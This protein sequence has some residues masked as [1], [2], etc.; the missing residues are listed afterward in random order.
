MLVVKILEDKPMHLI[1]V[2]LKEI[3]LSSLKRNRKVRKAE[4][5]KG[6]Q[7]T[8]REGKGSQGT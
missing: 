4:G 3:T 7:G 1:F 6:G 2:V 5:W 8:G